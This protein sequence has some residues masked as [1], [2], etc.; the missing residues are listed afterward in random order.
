MSEDKGQ[1]IYHYKARIGWRKNRGNSYT[2]HYKDVD[3]LSRAATLEMM[4]NDPQFIIEIMARNGL[5]GAKI[6]NFGVVKIYEIKELGRSF[7]YKE[8]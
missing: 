1:M 6:S 5:T 7:H 2:N 8:E 4:N 3:F